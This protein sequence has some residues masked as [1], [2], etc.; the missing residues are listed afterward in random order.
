[1][2]LQA[3]VVFVGNPESI[4]HADGY[5]RQ[6]RYRSGNKDLGIS[7]R[8]CGFK[9]T[10]VLKT[11]HAEGEKRVK[12][13]AL[14]K[15]AMYGAGGGEGCKEGDRGQEENQSR[16]HRSQGRKVFHSSNR[17]NSKDFMYQHTEL[18]FSFIC[19]SP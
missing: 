5:T 17:L 19:I 10:E 11:D 7:T 1:M 2:Q 13:K 18:Y 6:G 16:K 3:Q 15:A 8:F 14:R 12:G 9:A 4:S